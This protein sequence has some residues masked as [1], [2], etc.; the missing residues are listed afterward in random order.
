M[1]KFCSSCGSSI[2]ENTAFCANCGAP[3]NDPAPAATTTSTAT[4][5]AA[6]PAIANDAT[7]F[8]KNTI[9][10]I[11]AVAVALILLIILFANIFGGGYK[12]V[13]KEYYKATSAVTNCQYGSTVSEYGKNIKYKVE[14]KD[15]EKLD[16]DEI[17]EFEKKLKSNTGKKVSIDKAYELDCEIKIKGSKDDDEQDMIISVGKIDGKWYILSQKISK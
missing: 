2:P 14:F 8:G 11:G 6:T 15:K 13:V 3:A 12:K 9:I 1:S 7:K 16:K 17:K 10:A 4:P 5:T